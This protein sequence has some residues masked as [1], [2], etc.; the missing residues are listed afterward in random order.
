[1]TTTKE[2]GRLG[3][4]I[5]RN[6][7]VSIIAQKHNLQVNYCNNTSFIKLGLSL[8]MG[9]NIFENTILLTDTNYFN[10]LNSNDLKYNLNPNEN[11]FQTKEITNLLYKYLHSEPIKNNIIN[12]NKYKERYNNNNDLFVHIRLDDMAYNNPGL[13]YYI[14]TISRINHS[15]LYISTDSLNHMLILNLK[16]RFPKLVIINSDEINTIQFAS[17]CKN[18]ILSHG[19]FSAVI[20]YL[21]FFSQIYY[22]EYESGKIWYGDMFSINNWNK[23][24]V[25]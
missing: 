11:Y 22:P 25:K 6:I 15:N 20:G 24:S 18:I 12:N 2:I 5:I 17:T 23:C 14:N 3:N 9:S 1:M 13:Y 7:A 8:F 10:I 19:S 21:S 16:E 4:Q